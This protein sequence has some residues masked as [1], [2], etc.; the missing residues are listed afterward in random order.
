MAFITLATLVWASLATGFVTYYYLEQAKYQDRLNEKQQLLNQLTENHDVSVAKQ[1]LLS[2]DY[3]SLLGEYQW[4]SAENYSPLMNKYE[5]LLSNLCINYTSTLNEFPELN[6]TYGY[7]LNNF[8]A[9]QEKSQV[10]KDEFGSLLDDFYKLFMALTLKE[11]E[12]FLSKTVEEM[13]ASLCIDYGNLTIEWC[14]VSVSSSMTLFALTQKVA[15]V[16]YS[17]WQTMEPGHILITSINNYAEGYW[18]WYYW[19]QAKNEWIF[20]PVGC[21]AW[22]LN[23]KGTYKWVCSP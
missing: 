4:L 2:G 7:L 17:Y 13:T 1:N 3:G 16:E 8:Q 10:S 20:G 15:K 12:A 9:L 14:N 6:T 22:I 5:K 11:S 18:V 21:D 23:N 19:N